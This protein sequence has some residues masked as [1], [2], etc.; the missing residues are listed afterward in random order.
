[1]SSSGLARRGLAAVLQS[2]AAN[3]VKA[4]LQFVVGVMLARM[5]G[6]QEFGL[7]AVAWLVVGIGAL[8]MDIGLSS[9]I[10][11][12]EAVSPPDVAYIFYLQIL[13]GLALGSLVWFGAPALANALSAPQ[14]VPLIRAMTLVFVFK[15]A[16]QTSFALINRQMRF[17]ALQVITVAS[18]AIGFGGFALIMASL[19]YGPWSVVVAAIVQAAVASLAYLWLARPPLGVASL[20]PPTALLRFGAKTLGANLLSWVIFNADAM[21]V[22][23]FLGPTALGLYSRALALANLPTIIVSS[24]QPL[25]FSAASRVQSER[26]KIAQTFLAATN[27]VAMLV[28]PILIVTSVMATEVITGLYGEE[29]RAAAPLLTPL[30]L[31]LIANAFTLLGGPLLTSIDQVH[32]EVWAQGLTVAVMLVVVSLAA[33]HSVEAAAWAVFGVYLLRMLLITRATI[34][35][36]A[37]PISGYLR[38]LGPS[39]VLMPMLPLVLAITSTALAPD[40]DQEARL[41][42]IIVVSGAGY[43][44]ALALLGPRL[45]AGPLS[46]LLIRS[47][48]VPRLVAWWMTALAPSKS[49]K[50]RCPERRSR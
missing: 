42:L 19:G 21:L 17:G 6:P 28:G 29:W 5:L 12:S 41:A 32:R 25:L 3:L 48:R 35:A 27:A 45:S 49:N 37:I 16:G 11:Q 39:L 24:I 13:I 26:G 36:L 7:V 46:D 50:S 31:A 14:A 8:V 33:M 23:R 30:A 20:R 2:Y 47:G 43:A 44:V 4:V 1:M 10:I 15:A 38:A 18:Y 9:S 22:S 40:W 34:S